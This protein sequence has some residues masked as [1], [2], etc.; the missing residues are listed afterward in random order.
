[1]FEAVFWPDVPEDRRTELAG[2][3]DL[4]RVGACFISHNRAHLDSPRVHEIK[5]AG[6]PILCWTVRSADQEAEA[7]EIA[8]NI[9]FEGYSP[10]PHD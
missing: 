10:A 7:R 3:P 5:A 4:D 6:L 2:I 1:P 9:T 8:D